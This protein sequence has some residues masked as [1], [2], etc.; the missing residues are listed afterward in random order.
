MIEKFGAG[1]LH[2]YFAL[3]LLSAFTWECKLNC[4]I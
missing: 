4:A 2:F 1:S 3:N